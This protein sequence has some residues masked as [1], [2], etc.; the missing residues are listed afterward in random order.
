MSEYLTSDQL[1]EFQEQFLAWY[2]AAGRTYL[3][4]RQNRTAY[5]TW[6]SE[7][8]LQQTRVESVIP[9]F[10]KFMA[11]FPT[12]EDLAKAPEA[13][14]LK[15]WEGLGYYSRAR[16]LQIGAG[17]VLAE[18]SGEI[19]HEVENLLKIKGIGPYTAGA[20]SSMAF[21]EKVPAIDGNHM[22]IISRLFQI[23]D[24]LS[25]SKT[26]KKFAEIS[27]NLLPKNRA[28]DFNEALMDLGSMICTPKNP[29]CEICP[30]KNFCQ[31]YK[32]QTQED[33]PV[34]T[35]KTKAK[36][37][38]YVALALGNSSNEFYLEQRADSGLLANF[39]QFPLVAV[40]KEEFA[41]LS[42]ETADLDLFSVAEEN[43]NETELFLKQQFS[44][45]DFSKIVLQKRSLGN[46]QHI[47]SHLK[48]HV[49]LFYG[50][51]TDNATPLVNL[52]D[53][54]LPLPKAQHK[55]MALL[56]KNGYDF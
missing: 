21:N 14:V 44:Q 28:G 24:D 45:L 38:Y 19:P 10:Q 26:P 29:K 52:Q 37:V 12:V 34:K 11:A 53:T 55:L 49:T 36:D 20:I 32:E 6:V 8:M 54:K 50:R 15:N 2:E 16:N 35:P 5:G 40:T 17:Q 18:F 23:S 22:R 43:F 31:S 27:E 56:V 33:F 47:F 42:T 9:Y 39:W 3:P 25:L 4:W 30:L 13:E 7:I 51:T 1:K 48:W 46:I 41:K